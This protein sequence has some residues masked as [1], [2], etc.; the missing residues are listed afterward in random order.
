MRAITNLLEGYRVSDNFVAGE[1]RCRGAELEQPCSCHGAISVHP[2]LVAA[3][4]IWRANEPIIITSGFR[5]DTWNAHIGGHPR[6][7]HRLGYAAD[8]TSVPIRVDVIGCA[9]RVAQVLFDMLGA[10]RGNVIAY[11]GR[12]FIHVDVGRQVDPMHLVRMKVGKDLEPHVWR[13][14]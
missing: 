8:C 3:L 14:A 12:G 6:S 7:Y 11:E 2:D 10:G 13:P 9:E 1:F 4:Q 5:C